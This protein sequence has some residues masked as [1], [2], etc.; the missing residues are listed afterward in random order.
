MGPQDYPVGLFQDGLGGHKLA[1]DVQAV[2]VLLH[3][4]EDAVDLAPGGFQQ[5][6][7]LSVVGLHW[8]DTT[9]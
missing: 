1:G 3:H 9:S 5:A 8:T 4:F 6:V 7:D 2:A